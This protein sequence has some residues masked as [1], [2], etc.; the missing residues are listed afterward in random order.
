MFNKTFL[1]ILFRIAFY[2][3]KNP[4]L[5]IQISYSFYIPISYIETFKSNSIL[6]LGNNF[7]YNTTIPI[8]EANYSFILYIDNVSAIIEI[9]KIKKNEEFYNK[10]EN[11]EENINLDV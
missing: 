2:L 3:L 7:N 5:F 8:S 10:K 11:I 9:Q 6:S 1:S 4:N